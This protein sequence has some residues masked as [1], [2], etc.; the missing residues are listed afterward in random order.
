MAFL[1]LTRS[2]TPRCTATEDGK[3]LKISDL[4]VEGLYYLCS[5]NKGADRARGY[6]TPDLHPF[7]F[8]YAKIR[9]FSLK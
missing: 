7:L 9:I 3:R 6:R 4:K 8:V 2:D 5:K 1:F